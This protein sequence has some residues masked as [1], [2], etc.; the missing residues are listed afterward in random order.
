MMGWKNPSNR[1][2]PVRYWP[3][4]PKVVRRSLYVCGRCGLQARVPFTFRFIRVPHLCHT[5]DSA[6]MVA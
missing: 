6:V 4:A 2:D 3:V 1:W 5:K